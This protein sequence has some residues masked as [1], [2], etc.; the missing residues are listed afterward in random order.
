MML[1]PEGLYVAEKDL[2]SDPHRGC[3][4]FLRQSLFWSDFSAAQSPEQNHY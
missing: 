2:S 3:H 4:L 1:R